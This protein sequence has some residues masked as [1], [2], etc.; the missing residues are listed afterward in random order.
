VDNGFFFASLPPLRNT[1]GNTK[2][3]PRCMQHVQ[4]L[5]SKVPKHAQWVLA[6]GP[7]VADPSTGST[8]LYLTPAYSDPIPPTHPDSRTMKGDLQALLYSVT[9]RKQPTQPSLSDPKV[10]EGRD[11]WRT[12]D[13]KAR[14]FRCSF[15]FEHK[16][17]HAMRAMCVRLKLVVTT[18]GCDWL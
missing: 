18:R 6:D 7:C 12:K 15:E 9:T 5:S 11:E 8:P 14:H 17:H 10:T 4:R 3:V 13:A 2:V 1:C 16:L